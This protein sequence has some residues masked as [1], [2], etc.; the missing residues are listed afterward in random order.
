MIKYDCQLQSQI[1][2][3]INELQLFTEFNVLGIMSLT[4]FFDYKR[5]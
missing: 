4:V 3:K 5:K 1:Q 2:I